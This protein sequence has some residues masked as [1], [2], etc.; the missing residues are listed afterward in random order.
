MFKYS[1]IL[2]TALSFQSLQAENQWFVLDKAKKGQVPFYLQPNPQDSVQQVA[3]PDKDAS[4]TG[5]ATSLAEVPASSV[6]D[7]LAPVNPVLDGLKKVP[8]KQVQTYI[9]ESPK[10]YKKRVVKKETDKRLESLPSYVTEKQEANTEMLQSFSEQVKQKEILAVEV[11]ALMPDA[12]IPKTKSGVPSF[13]LTKTVKKTV[14]DKK[15][16]KKQKTVKIKVDEIPALNIGRE[17]KVSASSFE[18]PQLEALDLK[19]GKLK[20]LKSPKTLSNKSLQK[21]YSM[22]IKKVKDARNFDLQELVKADALVKKISETG[23]I[24]T[25]NVEMNIKEM[26]KIY[27]EEMQ[28]M[29]AEILYSKGD[30]CH[31]ATGIYYRLLKAKNPDYRSIAKLKVGICA[32]KMGLFTESVRRLLSVLDE[33]NEA[34]KKQALKAL[35]SDLPLGFQVK[36]GERLE[37]FTEYHLI[38]EADKD[39]FNYVIAKSLSKRDEFTKA[40]KYAEQ[41]KNTSPYYTRAQ[42]IA[43]VGEYLLG[44]KELAFRRQEQ[45]AKHIAEKGEKDPVSS[46]VA[47]SKARMNF[48]RRKYKE[49]IAEFLKIDRNHPMW[50]EGLQQQAWAQMMVKDEPGA[51]GNMHSI[52]T[53]FF[54]SVYKPES[55]VIRGLGYINLCQYA[56]AYKSVKNLEMTYKPKWNALKSF[57]K[58][59]KKKVFNYYKTAANYLVNP[60]QKKVNGIDGL[61]IREAVRHKDFLNLQDSINKTYDETEQYNFL[62]SLI[63][64]DRRSFLRLKKNAKDRLAKIRANL[65]KVKKD[66]KLRKHVNEWKTQIGVEKFLISYYNFR[67]AN[68]KYTKKGMQKFSADSKK[69]LRDRRNNLKMQASYV[70]KKRFNKMEASLAQMIQ[71]NELLKYEIFSGAGDNLRYRITGGKVVGKSK[72]TTTELKK[73]ALNWEFD[74]EFWEDEVGHYRSSLKNVCPERSTASM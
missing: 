63:D 16:K 21:L 58:K 31:A 23:F 51:I 67:I 50:I 6:Q 22:K 43:S 68:Y 2:V 61:A 18:V 20:A 11:P 36:I 17:S 71:N 72:A 13:S 7:L 15:G 37:K 19:Y 44:K 49:S 62:I 40:I 30:Q 5:E 54:R 32:H 65:A 14:T 26:H 45:I 28:F 35:L 52:H 24:V 41:V 38:E 34:S 25:Q 8:S 39:A 27:N 1:I 66:K 33:K 53:P 9:L 69:S 55:Y 60:K 57:N 59:N 29:Q 73:E 56:D 10:E 70:L 64:K 47:I 3:T 48:Q 12:S 4:N 46:L 42:Y 74:G